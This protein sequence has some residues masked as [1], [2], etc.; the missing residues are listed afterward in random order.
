MSRFKS[1]LWNFIGHNKYWLVIIIGLLIV[2]VLDENSFIKRIQYSMQKN[3]LKEQIEEF[4]KEH[5]RN[6]AQLH[7][8]RR[9]PATIRKIARERYF[10]KTDDE[11]IFVLSDDEKTPK[12]KAPGDET[13]E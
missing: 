6:K 4:D 9:D 10:M 12:S 11:D 7:E 2:G 8:L 3:E 1:A 5:Q 13:I